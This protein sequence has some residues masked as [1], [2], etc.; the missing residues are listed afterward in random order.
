MNVSLITV[1][2]CSLLVSGARAA[3]LFDFGDNFT[4][5]WNS[6][7]QPTGSSFSTSGTDVNGNGTYTVFSSDSGGN[8]FFQHSTSINSNRWATGMFDGVS[9]TALDEMQRTLGLSSPIGESVW[10]D[11]LHRGQNTGNT[12][13]IS[14]LTAGTGYT[15]YCIVG[16]DFDSS[17]NTHAITLSS[18]NANDLTSA[19][20]FT[21]ES[22]NGFYSTAPSATTTLRVNGTHALL[23]KLEN[24]VADTEG[25]VVFTLGG[26]RSAINAVAFTETVPEP[27][28]AA[29]GLLGAA[30]LMMRRRKA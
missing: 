6:Y 8:N 9:G 1:I 14:G 20:Y 4:D 23:V 24:V 10:R 26:Q 5:G 12:L 2:A 13:T 11:G 21:T 22:S 18:T 27:A 29:M 16:N 7:T 3:V 25:N 28:T 19:S 17:S 15:F 30:A